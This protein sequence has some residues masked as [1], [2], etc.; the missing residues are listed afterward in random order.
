MSDRTALTVILW[1]ALLAVVV[2]YW[3]CVT[4]LRAQP[5]DREGLGN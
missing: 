1:Y 4:E 5:R 2:K 3:P